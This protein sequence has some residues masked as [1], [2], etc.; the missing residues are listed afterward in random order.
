MFENVVWKTAAI[1]SRPQYVNISFL[2]WS[3]YKVPAILEMQYFTNMIIPH[4]TAV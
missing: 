4:L 3:P 2:Q 1:L